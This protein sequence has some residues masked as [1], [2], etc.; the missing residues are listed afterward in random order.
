MKEKVFKKILASILVIILT[1]YNIVL[2][3]TSSVFGATNVENVDFDAYFDQEGTKIYEK[4]GDVGVEETIVLHIEVKNNGELSDAKIQMNNANFEILKDKVQ[5]SYVKEINTQTN[6]ITLNSIIYGNSV[7]IQIPIKFKKQEIFDVNYFSQENVISFSGTYK[8]E[9]Q[10]EVTSEKRLK[11]NWTGNTDVVL[12]Q[13]IA[14]YITLGE[15]GVLIQQN[16]NSE[17]QG[18]VLPR[19]S[20]TLNINV[21]IISEQKPNDV[22][23]ILNGERLEQEKVNYNNETNL[24][25]IKIDNKVA[26][27][28]KYNWKTEK[29]DYQIIYIYPKE[30]GEDNKLVEINSTLK[31]KLFT[32]DEIQKKDIQ[33]DIEISPIGSLVDL[34]K[35]ILR[36]QIYKGYLYANVQN[37]VTFEEEDVINISYSKAINN[38]EIQTLENQ[39]I[40]VENLELSAINSVNYKGFSINKD[41]MMKYLGIDGN[42]SI[43]DENG[44]EIAK[45]DSNTETDENGNINITYDANRKNIKVITSKPVIEGK[46][47]FK[48]IKSIAGN[49]DYT[50]EEL[51]V[52]D[53]FVARSNTIVNGIEVVGEDTIALL[54]TKTEAKLEMNNTNLSVLQSNTDVQFL[55]TLKSNNE[56]YDLYKNP[57]IQIVLPKELNIQVKN[58]SQLNGQ[59]ELAIEKP[60]LVDNDDGTRTIL[61]PVYGEQ[62]S[63]ENN[64]NEGIQI[65]ITA[66][67]TMEKTVPTMSSKVI[68]NYTNENRLGENFSY[69]VPITLN[70]KYGVLL[71]NNLS[72]YNAN[73]DVLEN[74]D[75]KTKYATLDINSEA[76]VANENI[77]IVNNYETEITNV[78]LIGKLPDSGEETINDEQLKATFGI[79]LAN[80]IQTIG[81]SAKIYYSEDANA[82]KSSDTWVENVTDFSNIKAFK[83]EIEDGKLE[84]GSVLNV[85]TQLNIPEKLDNNQSTY[86]SLKLNYTYLGSEMTGNSNIS[87]STENK[88][89]PTEPEEGVVETVGDLSVEIV[90]TSGGKNLSDGQEVYEGQGIEYTI[91]VKNNKQEALNN[92]KLT[93]KNTNAIYFGEVKHHYEYGE[94]SEELTKIEEDATLK[95]KDF[96]IESLGV[97]EEKE[98]TYQISVKEVEGN[99]QVV[100]GEL[101]ISYEQ[102]ETQTL[103]MP[104]LKIK[105]GEL[106]LTLENDF[107]EEVQITSKSGLAIIMNV[108]NITDHTLNNVIVELPVPDELEFSTEEIYIDENSKYQ[109][110]DYKDKVAR[111]EVNNLEAG[112]NLEIATQL[113]TKSIPITELSVITEFNFQ[114]N[115]NDNKYISNKLYREIAQSEANVVANQTANLDKEYL[116]TNDQLTFTFTIENRGAKE[117]DVFINDMVPDGL[118]V[119]ESYI[120]KNGERIDLEAIENNVN[121]NVTLNSNTTLTWVINTIVDTELVETSTVVNYA[122]IQGG[123]TNIK[124][125]EI[126]YKVAGKEDDPLPEEETTYSISGEAWLDE[127]QNG[128]KDTSEQR[129]PNIPVMLIDEETGEMALDIYGNQ[130]YSTTQDDGIYKFENLEPKQYLIIMQYDTTTYRLTEYQKEG[131]EETTNSDFIAK[132]IDLDGRQMQ[133][134]VTG[135]LNLENQNLTDIDAGFIEGDKFD[136]KLDKYVNRIIVQDSVNTTVHQF[137]KEQLAKVEIDARRIN[138]ANV[139]IEYQIDVTNEGEV[140]GYANEIIDYIPNDLTF[141]SEINKEWYQGTDG[142]LHTKTL[143]NQII[144]PGETKTV[145]LTLMKKMN[146]N[147]TGTVINTAEISN[148]SNDFQLGDIDSTPGNKVTGEDDIS[149]AE[150]LISIRTGTIIMYTFLIFIIIAI[151]GVGIYFIN[152]KV[153]QDTEEE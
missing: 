112:E 130:V 11:I 118:Q 133:V 25:E 115:V 3:A 149:T 46:M 13:N 152:K 19:E 73:G 36:D 140:P 16:V 56:Q 125:N 94:V 21:P 38:M 77:S 44:V 66:D 50:K 74:I 139:I 69:E 142:N 4:T 59:D 27:E 22:Y 83:I 86:I 90:A 126:S 135:T 99:E 18:N 42:I 109:F 120:M 43:Q 54:D 33:T 67:I 141:T 17:V 52:F 78:S 87:L 131:I 51:K 114:A 110:I 122:T 31:T 116:E 134:A 93:A 68:M 80:A 5:N 129:L 61:I 121:G 146:Q 12:T 79:K 127:N 49:N 7:D 123:Y 62:I 89:I 117:I 153:L 26:N 145:I 8:N 45:I 143:E 82:D 138:N 85:N 20:E 35:N 108:K 97:G 64:I 28:E 39:F 63:F 81:K 101:Q 150:V 88:E 30:I 24:L 71:V 96:T 103:E 75:D 104:K 151:V 144:N 92:V 147:N 53:R 40:N 72:N 57:V 124:T 65:S 34:Q 37:E 9:T 132:N 47:K 58:I 41:H 148:A 136:L 6:E 107:Y 98:L 105:Q 100:E 10:Q 48:H 106:K 70:S 91:R 128:L 29:N 55:V 137:S 111:F 2:T 60:Q 32:K 76:K 113:L 84:P 95:Q 119:Q 14:K 23:V 102:E 15:E 1:G